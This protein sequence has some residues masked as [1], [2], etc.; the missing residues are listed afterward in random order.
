MGKSHSINDKT[1]LNS[2]DSHHLLQFRARNKPNPLPPA[3]IQMVKPEKS[4]LTSLN[5]LVQLRHI[6][7]RYPI[8]DIELRAVVQYCIVFQTT[9]PIILA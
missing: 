4:A 1:L 5:P 9:S 2:S 8:Y 3:K 7:C 6:N